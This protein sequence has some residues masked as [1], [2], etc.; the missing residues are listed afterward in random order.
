MNF[1]IIKILNFILSDKF[2]FCLFEIFLFILFLCAI[3]K[4]RIY[5]EKSIVSAVW[6]DEKSRGIFLVSAN[7]FVTLVVSVVFNMTSYPKDGKVLVYLL[8]L[9]MIIYLFLYSGWFT[10]KLMRWWIK[11]EQRNFNPHGQ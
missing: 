6:R 3:W 1:D 9:G 7:V 10:N 4:D 11:F 5:P 2:G 8:N